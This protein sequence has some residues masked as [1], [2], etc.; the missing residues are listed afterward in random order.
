MLQFICVLIWVVK[1]DCKETCTINDE[2]D[3]CVV[4]ATCDTL[5][6]PAGE[7]EH[8]PIPEE[9]AIVARGGSCTS[10]LQSRAQKAHEL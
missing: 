3:C 6:C 8:V 5:V 1:R 10:T 4:A 9:V 7:Y 2:E